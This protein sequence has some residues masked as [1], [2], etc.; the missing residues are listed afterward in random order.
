MQNNS[1]VIEDIYFNSYEHDQPILDNTLRLGVW[2]YNI[3]KNEFEKA[4]NDPNIKFVCNS[5]EGWSKDLEE[6]LKRIVYNE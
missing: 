6:S 1:Y 4:V 5:V 3:Y 2:S